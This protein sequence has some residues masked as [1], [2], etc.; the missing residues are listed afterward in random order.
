M[1]SIDEIAERIKEVMH[2][3]GESPTS[4]ADK[5]QV[6]RLPKGIGRL[7]FVWKNSC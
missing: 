5:L 1:D 7:Y 3:M 4:F 2:Q 6:A